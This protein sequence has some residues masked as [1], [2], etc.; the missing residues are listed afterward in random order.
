MMTAKAVSVVA[1]RARALRPTTLLAVLLVTLLLV[2]LVGCRD[3]SD[4][5]AGSDVFGDAPTLHPI[6]F[7]LY[8]N[9]AVVSIQDSNAAL[10]AMVEQRGPYAAFSLPPGDYR[11]EVRAEGFRT[12]RGDFA[13]PQNQN[14]SVTLTAL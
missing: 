11:Y 10:V 14:L 2:G 7:R 8:P 6:T 9:H 4:A 1:R 5:D 12:Y 13:I 3:D